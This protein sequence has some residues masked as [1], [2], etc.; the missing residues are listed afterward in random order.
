MESGA[1]S[2]S[3]QAGAG[4]TRMRVSVQLAGRRTPLVV[5]LPQWCET[6]QD[7]ADALVRKLEAGTW[8]QLEHDVVEVGAGLL[9][10][11]VSWVLACQEMC[12]FMD[13][14]IPP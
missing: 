13:A 12:S 5:E 3:R 11:L 9:S 8:I 10:V 7:V 2:P 6:L 4:T 14:T 1:L